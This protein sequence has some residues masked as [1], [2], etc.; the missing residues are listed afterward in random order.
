MRQA[1][2][3]YNDYLA[4]QSKDTDIHRLRWE[5]LYDLMAAN[6]NL[7]LFDGPTIF[8]HF[9]EEEWWHPF[10]T[11][12]KPVLFCAPYA[13]R[14]YQENGYYS[15]EEKDAGK[16]AVDLA[17]WTSATICQPVRSIRDIPYDKNPNCNPL[18]LA[19]AEVLETEPIHLFLELHTS[20]IEEN[21]L[22]DDL[23]GLSILGWPELTDLLQWAIA[24]LFQVRKGRTAT[25]SLLCEWV[26]K[27][28]GIP[29]LSLTFSTRLLEPNFDNCEDEQEREYERKYG[30]GGYGEVS[31][32]LSRGLSNILAYC[33]HIKNLRER[34]GY[35]LFE[36]ERNGVASSLPIPNQRVIDA[37]SIEQVLENV[38][39]QFNGGNP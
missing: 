11:P 6:N 36:D 9:Y 13:V 7:G 2:M 20:P 3:T 28:F 38:Y 18:L 17:R 29:S 8:T 35:I 16:I 4:S 14:N 30:Y 23:N 22:I 1:R 15:F 26:R 21:I 10:S 31:V 25:G 24:P 32:P 12:W 5:Y 27:V 19:L 33:R 34:Q 37:D 39:Q